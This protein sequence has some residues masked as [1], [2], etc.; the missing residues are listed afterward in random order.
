MVFNRHMRA[1]L[2]AC[3]LGLIA[4]TV[5][6]AQTSVSLSNRV[7]DA[8]YR[9][10]ASDPAE[11][12]AGLADLMTAVAADKPENVGDLPGFLARHED[13]KDPVLSENVAK[14]AYYA[15]IPILGTVRSSRLLTARRL[16]LSSR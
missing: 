9:M 16:A 1:V 14:W 5:G 13:L 10:A 6:C 3:V 12:E 11:R 8:L 15:A 4:T 2:R 7:T